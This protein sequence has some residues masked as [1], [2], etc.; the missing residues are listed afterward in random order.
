MKLKL[1]DAMRWEKDAL[2]AVVI[3]SMN[4]GSNAVND[5]WALLFYS[6]DMAPNVTVYT[7][8]DIGPLELFLITI[9]ER[10]VGY[11]RDLYRYGDLDEWITVHVQPNREEK[12]IGARGRYR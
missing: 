8:Y 10:Y 2:R 11:D 7:E 3:A 5:W 12:A 6:A 9:A 4:C 1:N